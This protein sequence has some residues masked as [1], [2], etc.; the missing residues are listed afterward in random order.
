MT[1]YVSIIILCIV[2]VSH[3]QATIVFIAGYKRGVDNRST[4]QEREGVMGQ[5]DLNWGAFDHVSHAPQLKSCNYYMLRY[6]VH[7]FIAHAL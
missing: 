7:V 1:L 5:Q 6:V 2:L 3:R 4:G